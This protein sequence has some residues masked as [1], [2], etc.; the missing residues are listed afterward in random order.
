[1]F[2]MISCRLACVISLMLPLSLIQMYVIPEGIYL[3]GHSLSNDSFFNMGIA[4]DLDQLI[5]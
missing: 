1:M 2:H 4:S 3:N 5:L